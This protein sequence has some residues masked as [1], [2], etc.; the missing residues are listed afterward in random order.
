MAAKDSPRKRI[1]TMENSDLE[2]SDE[3]KIMKSENNEVAVSI[4][5]VFVM[6]SALTPAL[7]C[8]RNVFI[9]QT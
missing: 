9:Y 8:S 2:N 6:E 3:N 4:R 1:R 5:N 7:S